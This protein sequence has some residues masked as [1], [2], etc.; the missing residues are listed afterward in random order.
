MLR[1]AR[2]GPA[3]GT[4]RP[5]GAREGRSWQLSATKKKCYFKRE[6]LPFVASAQGGKRFANVTPERETVVGIL[7]KK[8]S[9]QSFFFFYVPPEISAGGAKMM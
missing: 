1:G 6:P 9:C 4:R 2:G 8:M 5:R 3:P 7:V